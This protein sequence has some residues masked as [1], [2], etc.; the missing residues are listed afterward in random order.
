MGENSNLPEEHADKYFCSV[1]ENANLTESDRMCPLVKVENYV[2]LIDVNS[3]GVHNL[4]GEIGDDGLMYFDAPAH[5]GPPIEDEFFIEMD[6]LL[7]CDEADASGFEML[8]EYLTYFDATNDNLLH[9]P[10]D[11]SPNLSER[12]DYISNPLIPGSEVYTT[13]K[14]W[15]A[16]NHCKHHGLRHLHH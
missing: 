2:E 8:D 14:P 16:C 9:I 10:Q 6:D 15:K 7:N 12:V 1:D 5:N 4:N 3:V 11:S 13:P